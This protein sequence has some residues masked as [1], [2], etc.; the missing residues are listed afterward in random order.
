MKWRRGGKRSATC[1]L[2]G[3]LALGGCA[4]GG[5]KSDVAANADSSA[6]LQVRE[7][8][9]S[10]KQQ[11]RKPLCPEI[12]GSVDSVRTIDRNGDSILVHARDGSGDH[13]VALLTVPRDAVSAPTTFRVHV[14]G[15]PHVVAFVT[16]EQGKGAITSFAKDL[17]LTLYYD[18]GCRV[19]G[20]DGSLTK[21]TG[22]RTVENPGNEG[23][24]DADSPVPSKNDEVASV[25]LS[26][27]H[28]SG[29]ILAQGII[30]ISPDTTA[31]DSSSSPRR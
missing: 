23:E 24:P 21:L 12:M 1:G 19:P 9:A 20:P 14:P 25:L 4:A 6:I 17:Q 3:I 7:A 27:D 11:P 2:F 13:P 22:F 26:L 8:N 16:A 15:G 18:R 28:L 31:P 5:D 29:Y 10:L 30:G